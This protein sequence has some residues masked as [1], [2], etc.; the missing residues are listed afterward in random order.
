MPD[1]TGLPLFAPFGYGVSVTPFRDA[2]SRKARTRHR[3]EQY[4]AE[5][6]R[7]TPTVHTRPHTG[8]ATVSPRCIAITRRRVR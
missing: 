7:S 6:E 5:R 2:R 4:L 8:H 1:G 3:D